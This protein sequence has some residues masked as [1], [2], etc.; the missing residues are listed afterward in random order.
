M[1]LSYIVA[2]KWRQLFAK[3]MGK[4]VQ[5]KNNLYHRKAIENTKMKHL[6]EELITLSSA[7]VKYVFLVRSS[8]N[9]FLEML[10]LTVI[11]LIYL[12]LSLICRFVQTT[13]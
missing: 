9:T 10:S 11:K 13:S 5:D 7:L 2:S 4:N 8:S 12:T 3:Q 1:I 6:A